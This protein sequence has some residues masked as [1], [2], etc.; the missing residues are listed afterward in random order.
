M[1]LK[2]YI[3][4]QFKGYDGAQIDPIRGRVKSLEDIPNSGSWSGT[5]AEWDAVDKST[6]PDGI[7]VNL[8][9]DYSGS[10]YGTIDDE[11]STTS[12]NPVQNKVIT[13]EI[14]TIKTNFQD[15]VDT[16]Y[17]AAVE[18]G[19]TPASR[20]PSAIARAI[21]T[22][23]K[24]A[25]CEGTVEINGQSS[26]VL[27]TNVENIKFF[28]IRLD[29]KNY[30]ETNC[31]TVLSWYASNPN[32]FMASWHTSSSTNGG[33]TYTLG[34]SSNA[35]IFILDSVWLVNGQITLK[36]PTGTMYTGTATW[37]AF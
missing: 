4:K 13:N 19:A 32:Y 27:I 14:N 15:G 34:R 7:I 1:A 24:G 23:P 12:E 9:D 37:Y 22:M 28:N 16:V 10:D 11:L 36:A 5:K 31:Y 30:P 18:A 29:N 3:L 33:D 6:I 21:A 25:G 17:N 35:N 26:L 20:T 8:T 2:D